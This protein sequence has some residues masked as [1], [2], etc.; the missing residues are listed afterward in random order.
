MKHLRTAI[1]EAATELAR[2]KGLQN[3]TQ[4]EV[5][6]KA[7]AAYGMIHY[8]F[9]S[10]DGL[11]AEVLRRAIQHEDLAIVAQGLAQ[12]HPMTRKLSASLKR[13][14]ALCLA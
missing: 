11:R 3:I 10:M 13:R 7:G 1:F 12:K 5:V 14:A 6:R 9:E 8:H 2:S 4:G